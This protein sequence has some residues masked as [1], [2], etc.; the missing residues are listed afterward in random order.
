MAAGGGVDDCCWGEPPG[1]ELGGVGLG[2][3]GAGAVRE[4][5]LAGCVLA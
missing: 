4:L 1:G 3:N 2:G 5:G